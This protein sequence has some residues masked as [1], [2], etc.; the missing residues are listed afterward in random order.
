MPRSWHSWTMAAY[1][2]LP[3]HWSVLLTNTV[4]CLASTSTFMGPPLLFRQ[5]HP[6]QDHRQKHADEAGQETSHGVGQGQSP[7]PVTD[8]LERLPLERGERRVAAAEPGPERHVPVLVLRQPLQED[9]GRH[10]EDERAAHV[11]DQGAE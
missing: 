11:D 6:R 7:T 9:D 8:Q 2:G 4:T 1:R 10:A 3:C 5:Q